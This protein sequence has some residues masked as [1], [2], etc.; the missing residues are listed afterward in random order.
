MNSQ[1]TNY[2]LLKIQTTQMSSSLSVVLLIVHAIYNGYEQDVAI[3][4][5]MIRMVVVCQI[6]KQ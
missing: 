3:G 2:F 4:I 6:I 5:Q 1:N